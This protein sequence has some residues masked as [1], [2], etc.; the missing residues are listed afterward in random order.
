MMKSNRDAAKDGLLG[1]NVL[2]V[3]LAAKAAPALPQT[4]AALTVPAPIDMD[5]APLSFFRNHMSRPASGPRCG[6]VHGELACC[7]D[8][9]HVGTEHAWIDPKGQCFVWT[10]IDGKPDVVRHDGTG[11]GASA[12]PFAKAIDGFRGGEYAP[13]PFDGIE[14]EFVDVWSAVDP[15]LGATARMILDGSSVARATSEQLRDLAE[16]LGLDVGSPREAIVGALAGAT[17]ETRANPLRALN[18]PAGA[19]QWALAPTWP[20]PSDMAPGQVWDFADFGCANGRY[21]V[22]LTYEN[23]HAALL[24]DRGDGAACCISSTLSHPEKARCVGFELSDG[25]RIMIGEVRWDDVTGKPHRVT[26]IRHGGRVYLTAPTGEGVEVP[27][28]EA[29]GWPAR[30]S[31]VSALGWM[32]MFKTWTTREWMRLSEPGEPEHLGRLVAAAE[33]LRGKPAPTQGLVRALVMASMVKRFSQTDNDRFR[34]FVGPVE[35][36]PLRLPEASFN[37]IAFPRGL[38]TFDHVGITIATDVFPDRLAELRAAFENHQTGDLIVPM[39]ATVR[40]GIVEFHAD[41]SPTRRDLYKVTLRFVEDDPARH[42]RAVLQTRTMI[43]P[44][45]NLGVSGAAACDDIVQ[46]IIDA[47]VRIADSLATGP[48]FRAEC[49]TSDVHEGTQDRT[50]SPPDADC[51]PSFTPGPGPAVAAMLAD[52]WVLRD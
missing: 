52:G 5:G 35:E 3:A 23:G 39:R 12:L 44:R 31:S 38:V 19:E 29:A 4:T 27:A 6:R 49:A 51:G 28:V 40:A 50:T 13:R 15:R 22:T 8:A 41:A 34:G 7:L 30:L 20:N 47:T 46:S 1:G 32:V 37:G 42:L 43:L 2:E 36:S 48:S 33:A 10:G 11:R 17:E 45:L 24:S 21:V 14:K 26:E 18:L 25:R 16:L 9:G